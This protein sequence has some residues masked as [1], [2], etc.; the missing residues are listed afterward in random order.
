MFLALQVIQTSH[1]TSARYSV[2]LGS[3][4]ICLSMANVQLVQ[5]LPFLFYEVLCWTCPTTSPPTLF[6]HGWIRIWQMDED[7]GEVSRVFGEDG[8]VGTAG[9][10]W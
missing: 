1:H 10:D 9:R 5:L 6:I 4:F 3:C 2:S 8:M 7:Q